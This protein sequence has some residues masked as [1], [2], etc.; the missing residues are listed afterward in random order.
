MTIIDITDTY[1]Y[2]HSTQTLNNPHSSKQPLSK[3][4]HILGN[5]TSFNKYRTVDIASYILCDHN[6][7]NVNA[8]SNRNYRRHTNSGMLSNTLKNGN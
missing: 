1:M 5:K 3:T 2:K 7:K 6:S 8:D 4:E